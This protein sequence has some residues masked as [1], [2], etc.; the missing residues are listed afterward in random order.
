M[1]EC[2]H[3]AYISSN[4]VGPTVVTN[5]PISKWVLTLNNIVEMTKIKFTIII[6]KIIL[7]YIKCM[8][9]APFVKEWGVLNTQLILGTTVYNINPH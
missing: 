8:E 9:C 1:F 6:I 4:S 3:F 2:L 5:T 7:A